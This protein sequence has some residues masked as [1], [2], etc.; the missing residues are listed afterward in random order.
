MLLFASIVV[1]TVQA[2]QPTRLALVGG[3]LLVGYGGAPVHARYWAWTP[4][5][6]HR[7]TFTK[8]LCGAKPRSSWTTASRSVWP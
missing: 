5:T 8:T 1:A 3:M 2:S 7:S 4:I 6:E